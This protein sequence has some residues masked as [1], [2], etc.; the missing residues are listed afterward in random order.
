MVKIFWKRK[1]SYKLRKGYDTSLLTIFY[2]GDYDKKIYFWE[3][4]VKCKGKPQ[5]G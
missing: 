5:A 2:G 4:V 1:Q 3:L